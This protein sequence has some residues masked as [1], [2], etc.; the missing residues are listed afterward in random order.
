MK[1]MSG[2]VMAPTD[3][4]HKVLTTNEFCQSPLQ[5]QGGRAEGGIEW[6]KRGLVTKG[7]NEGVPQKGVEVKGW[8]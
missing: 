5:V 8:G 7:P 2:V 1:Y 3:L 6:S 4:T